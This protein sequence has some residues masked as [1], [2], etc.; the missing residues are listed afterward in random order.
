MIAWMYLLSDLAVLM[1]VYQT[2]N[3]PP[4]PRNMSNPLAKHVKHNPQHDDSRGNA[5]HCPKRVFVPGLGDPRV[6]VE[7]EEEAKGGCAC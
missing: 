3:K 5:R 4:F 2:L 6:G 1:P 7:G